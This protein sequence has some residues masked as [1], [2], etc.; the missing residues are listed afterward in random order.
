MRCLAATKFFLLLL[1]MLVPFSATASGFQDEGK[2]VALVIGT[3]AYESVSALPNP[4]NDAR[5]IAAAFTRLQF[6]V[7]EALDKRLPEL[8]AAI[9]EFLTKLP[10]TD[11]AVLYYAG[12]SIQIDNEN[13]LIPTDATFDTA[14]ALMEQVVPVSSI[15][16]A[17]D[18]LAKT[19]IVVLDACRDNPFLEIA[20]SV[21]GTADDGRSLAQGL[22]AIS[23]P[24][25][26]SQ[27]G[28]SDYDTYG[29]VIAYA[30][31]PGRTA[32]DGD[33]EHSPYTDALLQFMERP[34][35]EVGRMFREVASHV[36]AETENQQKPEYLVRLTD[37]VFF[38]RPEPNQ[39]DY[40]AIAPFN[41]V[42]IAGVEF[43]K[44]KPQPAIDACSVAI[45]ENPE[46]PRYLYNLGRAY[47]AAGKYVQAV[48]HYRQSADLGYVHAI[49]NLG[50]M[51]INGQGTGQDFNEGVRL[52][53]TA[54][55]LG[56]RQARISLR[57]SDFS[58]LFEK[59]EF[60]QLQ[61]AL[62]TAG[63]YEGAIDG[64]F[65]PGSQAALRNFQNENGFQNNG[66]T[67]ETLDAL[68][69]LSIIPPYEL[70]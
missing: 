29:T 46:H 13:Y 57:A 33:G 9:G 23:G 45:A 10:D 15:I 49:S 25:D 7:I 22:A 62:K 63:F 39:C 24:E 66:V 26:I 67:L 55:S 40:L 30:A 68:N 28:S 53:K 21:L 2:R 44:I 65:G 41:Q 19:K 6:D 16:G 35:L 51:H 37:E 17:M 34:G 47:D 58:V 64:D 52:L 27:A 59:A 8:K 36:I 3:G 38:S 4:G 14:D 5:A 11:I 56:S 31:A 20:E 1:A 54:K 32:S 69:A 18:R 43:E 61:A 60:E 70:N 48:R 12:H 50:V 42:G